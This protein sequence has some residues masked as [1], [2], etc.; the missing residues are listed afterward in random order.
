MD[1]HTPLARYFGFGSFRPGQQEALGHILAGHDLL[2]VMPT[3]SGKSLIYQLA[4]LLLPGTTL[5][6]S[7]LVALMKDQVDS[8]VRRHIPATF[9]NSSLNMAE[10]NRR[11][12]GLEEGRFRILLVAPE[13]LRS[14]S[15]RQALARVSL[16]LL[17]VDEAH[18]LSQ[19]GHDFRPDYLHVAD[20]RRDFQSHPPITL[21]LTATAT[22]RVQD[23][24][25]HLLGLPRA[26]RL[27]TGFNRENLKLEVLS[28]PDVKAKL[29][30]VREILASREGATIIYA[31]TRHDVEEVAEFVTQV[32]GLNAVFYHAGLDADTRTAIQDQFLAGDV[33]VIVATN[34]F[35][36]GIDR[37]DVRLVLHYTMPGTLE[38]YYQEAG[39]AGRDGLPARAVL[40]HSAR[41]AGL[42]EFFINNNSPTERDLSILH[43]FLQRTPDTSFEAIESSTGIS[44]VKTRV[45]VQEL[46]T[47]GV[48][49]R[50]PSDALGALCVEVRTLPGAQLA[51][52][53]RH[54][55]TRQE[56]RRNLLGR[57]VSYAETNEC[58]RRVILNYFGDRGT[59]DAA[60]CCDNCQVRSEAQSQP[61]R[62]VGTPLEQAALDVLDAVAQIKWGLGKSRVAL[63][64][65]GS[66]SR[67][68]QGLVKLATFGKLAGLSLFEIEALIVQLIEAGY[69]K[70][71]G[72]DRPVL[73]LTS[74][75]DLARQA[76]A[77]IDVTLRPVERDAAERK[78]A[79]RAASGTI[80]LTG[81]LLKQGLSP[82]QIAE[83]RALTLGTVYSHLAQLIAQ[84]DADVNAVV[85]NEIQ[86]QIRTAI[87]RAGSAGRLAPIKELLPSEIDYSVIRCVVEAWKREATPSTGIDK[88]EAVCVPEFSGK[89][90]P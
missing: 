70:Q 35:G 21:A 56:Y 40:L 30:F 52:V 46:E 74:R 42:H 22:L 19:W 27:V 80:T 38:A 32:V 51:T 45:A 1:L 15:F 77:A 37:P 18:C 29:R 86:T 63:I 4:A 71:V 47:V 75:G 59:A 62:T 82:A 25:I 61:V 39:R 28:A 79:E 16:K 90:L 66:S 14:G 60:I 76:R 85:P 67:D 6:I 2:A 88:I 36:M 7:P 65:K 72:A 57:M 11:M 55:A 81:Q 24:I 23:D 3:G 69:L 5:V 48:I 41:D 58:R 33:P 10:V 49:R 44:E 89:D 53:A 68:V 31:G 34:A 83:K 8:L 20:V 9:I 43:G 84:G 26:E 73:R 17:V 54:I 87:A 13:R 64:L 78:K 12:A 50:L